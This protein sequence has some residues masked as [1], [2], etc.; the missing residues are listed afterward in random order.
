MEQIPTCHRSS[1][2]RDKLE[3]LS[4]P[5]SINI[6][7]SFR[8]PLSYAFISPVFVH[9]FSVSNDKLT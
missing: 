3:L 4:D 6:I 1:L 5:T 9:A 8:F 2:T 7:F